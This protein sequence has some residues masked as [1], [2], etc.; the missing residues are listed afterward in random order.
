MQLVL[1]STSPY[2]RKLFE[3]LHVPFTVVDSGIDE[4]AFHQLTVAETVRVVSEAKARALLPKYGHTDTV[5]VTAD[6][7][8]ELDE[9]FLG[10][11][12]SRQ[13]AIDTILSYSDREMFIW[14]G[15]TVAFTATE[16]FHTD[17]RKA[18]IHFQP[19]TLEQVTRYVDEKNP[20]DKGGSIA[21]EEIEDRGFV[22]S[23]T[24][25]RAAIIGLSLEFV[26][27]MLY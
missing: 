7:A 5:V 2:K 19:L 12:T 4:T 20:L 26:R 16:E 9:K 25:E 15:T 1:G 13:D 14:T 24:G 18:V 8:G 23:I 21:I 17:V 27:T 22:R 3:Q 11:P 10:K 6:V